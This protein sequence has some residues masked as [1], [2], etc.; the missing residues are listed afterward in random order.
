MRKVNRELA[1]IVT[2]SLLYITWFLYCEKV[3]GE[4]LCID[5]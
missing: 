1:I 5:G 2:L 3:G 4:L